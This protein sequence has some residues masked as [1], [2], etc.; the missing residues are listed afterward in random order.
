MPLSR[1]RRC[2]R[3]SGVPLCRGTVR[4]RHR[5]SARPRCPCAAGRGT[6]SGFAPRARRIRPPAL[7][8]QGF[9]RVGLRRARRVASRNVSMAGPWR[10]ARLAEHPC[11]CGPPD[12][13]C[14]KAPRDP[15]AR[16]AVCHVAWRGSGMDDGRAPGASCDE[17]SGSWLTRRGLESTVAGISVVGCRSAPGRGANV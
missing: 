12:S 13:R 9:R 3:R 1:P 15:G 17:R 6:G 8:R 2:S 5:S 14:G 10:F 16:S 11:R 7:R 4:C